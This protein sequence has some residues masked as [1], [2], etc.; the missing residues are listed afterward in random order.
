MTI[1]PQENVMP[2]ALPPN[3]LMAERRASVIAVAQEAGMLSGER[4]PVS[5]RV[6]VTLMAAVKAR[7]GLTSTTDILEYAL[8][9]VA[10]EDDF[11]AMLLELEGTID[12]DL[13]LEF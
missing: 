12:P 11:G 1:R 2:D 8:A 5:A 4:K 10:I 3:A 7:T 6:S 9:K 13:D